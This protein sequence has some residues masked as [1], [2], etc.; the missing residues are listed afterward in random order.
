MKSFV[1]EVAE[2]L[3]ARY[4]DDLSPIKILF[5]SKRARLFFTEALTQIVQRPVWQP[6]WTTVDELMAEI[7]GL[8]GGERIRLIAELYKI[9]SKYHENESFE[10]F[11]FWGDMLLNDFDTIDRYMIDARQLLRNLSEIKEMESDLSYL[12]PEQRRIVDFWRTLA[13]ETLSVEQQRFVAMWRTL[14]PIYCEFRER[15]SQLGIAYG[16]MIYRRAAETLRAGDVAAIEGGR[17]AV[18]GFN[19]LSECEK[20]LFKYMAANAETDFFWDYDDYY[21]S[22]DEQEAGHF[23]RHNITAFPSRERISHDNMRSAAKHFESI[24]A[25][26]DAAQCKYAARILASLADKNGSTGTETAVVLTD[27]NILLPMLYALPANTGKVNVTMGYPLKQSLAY[28][29]MERLTELQRHARGE[30]DETAFYHADVLGILSHPFLCDDGGEAAAAR[31]RNERLITVEARM[32]GGTPLRDAIFRRAKGWEEMSDYLHDAL[33]AAAKIEYEGAEARRRVEFLAL[34]ADNI[35]RLRNSI[36][37]CGITIGEKTYTTLLRRHMQT[38]RVPFEGEPLEGIQIMGI[39]ETRNIDFENVL[40]LS[41]NDDN[42]PGNR[43]SQPSFIP[44]NLRT[45]FGMPTPEHHESVYAYYFYRLI[46]R[47]KN[48]YMIYCSHADEK[49]TGEESRYIRQLKLESGFDIRRV[50][51]GVD[52]GLS[53][54]KAIEVAKTDTVAE[55]LE[56]FLREDNPQTLSPTALARFIVCPLKFYFYSI[57]GIKT[58]TEISDDVDNPMFGTLLHSAMQRLYTPLAGMREPAE[59]LRRIVEGDTVARAVADAVDEEYLHGKPA[60]SG[61][62][63]SIAL[64]SNVITEYIRRGI[65]RYD[66]A[67]GDFTVEALEHRVECG[68]RLDDTRRIV[69]AGIADRIDRLRDGRLRVIDYKT[70]K[71]HNDFKGIDSLFTEGDGAKNTYI[72]QTML[73]SMMLARS[74]GADAKPCLYFAR[75][76]SSESYSPDIVRKEEIV[77]NRYASHTV[78]SYGEYAEEFEQSLRE[79]LLRLFDMREPFR[80]C[81]DLN[82]CRNCDYK[83]IC[84]R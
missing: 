82:A 69:F 45:A 5:P 29:F 57:A 21:T 83:E 33:S 37:E 47:A 64:A 34:M 28:S 81:S 30:G 44:Y 7:S 58:G 22:H 40:I 20:T 53:H 36:R 46:Q 17:Y 43:F 42:F 50:N 9:Y 63:G 38:L 61:Y 62:D 56:A 13:G 76:M 51:V 4:G 3:T 60:A 35:T 66:A 8:Q 39:L 19:A 24:A 80:Q 6:Q 15:L 68:F 55:R 23:L 74:K 1:Q 67:H 25:V 18:V 48:V 59:A 16:G 2:C 75:A 12:T 84:R 78:E 70:G 72:L 26:S 65:V 49:S 71:A 77:R 73:Y 31:I 41:M 32:L 79:C 27:E 14:Y 11:Y 10:Q 54:G 52:A